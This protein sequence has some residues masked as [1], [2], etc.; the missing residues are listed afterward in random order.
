MRNPVL[1][2][3]F[4]ALMIFGSAFN[5]VEGRPSTFQ[6]IVDIFVLGLGIFVAVQSIMQLRR[7]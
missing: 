4:A 6:L 2:V 1:L 3:L 5:F 7:R